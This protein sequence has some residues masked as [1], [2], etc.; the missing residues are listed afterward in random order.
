MVETVILIVC[1][2]MIIL[3]FCAEWCEG[4]HKAPRFVRFVRHLAVCCVGVIIGGVIYCAV[5][6]I[7]KIFGG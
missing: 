3:L 7:V 5:E 1:A 6:V 2:A 4:E